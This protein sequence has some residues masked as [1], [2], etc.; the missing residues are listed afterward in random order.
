MDREIMD[1]DDYL[2]NDLE[3]HE[4]DKEEKLEASKL[5]SEIEHL[6]GWMTMYGLPKIGEI[7]PG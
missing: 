3:Y 2:G 6:K 5:Q 7:L 1:L 4:E